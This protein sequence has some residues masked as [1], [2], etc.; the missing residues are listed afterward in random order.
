MHLASLSYP[1]SLIRLLP[2]SPTIDSSVVPLGVF[3]FGLSKKG[4]MG[5]CS[6]EFLD[7]LEKRCRSRRE[8]LVD[9][10]LRSRTGGVVGPDEGPAVT[11]VNQG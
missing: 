5:W 4:K 2:M 8:I 7:S 11:Q 10:R 1:L 6:P 9:L 3:G